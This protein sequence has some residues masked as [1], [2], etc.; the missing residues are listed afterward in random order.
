M[1]IGLDFDGTIVD[2]AQT[3]IRLAKKYGVDLT[4]QQTVSETMN[5]CVPED[6]YRKIQ[7]ELYGEETMNSRPMAGAQKVIRNLCK[8][9]SGVFVV[10]RRG[11]GTGEEIDVARRW[12]K[13]FM[14]PPLS[15]AHLFFVK[16]D[17]EKDVV[18][19][20]LGVSV[21]LDDKIGVLDNLPSVK[22]KAFFD[23]FGTLGSAVGQYP[24]L[25]SWEE[26]Y[27]FVKKSSES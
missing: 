2:H 21:F 5:A 15:D 12:V 4:P 7:K 14:S 16:I 27:T 11:H 20:S 22:Y 19:K 17:K 25:T 6:I 10:S 3:K 18:C 1:V 8:L 24:R 13:K 26:F 23:Q 9:S